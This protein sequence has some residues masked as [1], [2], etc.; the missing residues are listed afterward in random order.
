MKLITVHMPEEY[1]A[2]L[3]EIV[4]RGKYPSRGEAIRAAVRRLI[5]KYRAGGMMLG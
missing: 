2:A 5:S 3:D 4:R 1:I